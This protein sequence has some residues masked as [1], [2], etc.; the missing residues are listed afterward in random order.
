VLLDAARS[1]GRL[2]IVSNPAGQIAG[3]LHAIRSAKTMV[4]DMTDQATSRLKH[5]AILVDL[6][7]SK[8]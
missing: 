6:D 1:A 7:A 5:G 2:D 3:M 4:C 8:R